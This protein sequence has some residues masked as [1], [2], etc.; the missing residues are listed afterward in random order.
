MLKF[1]F[2][3]YTCT[4]FLVCTSLYG[5]LKFASPEILPA[6]MSSF[7]GLIEEILGSI[8]FLALLFYFMKPS[9]KVSKY[10]AHVPATATESAH[11]RFKVVNCSLFKAYDFH[12]DMYEMKI[13]SSSGH[14][15]KSELMGS[16]EGFEQGTPY[17]ESGIL[18]LF[19]YTKRNAAQVRIK[20]LVD[21]DD[22]FKSALQ[23]DSF[24]E[25]HISF[26]H[27]LSG[28]QGHYIKRYHSINCIRSGMFGHGFD[29]RIS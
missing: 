19:Q 14:N 5:Y 22:V 25:L 2:N 23:S 4:T 6:A 10:I 17:L 15:V 9:I 16:Y 8:L 7:D 13:V 21:S 27:G 29:T 12:V 26:R 11:L 20:R 3:I 28:L 1:L 18:S 24:V